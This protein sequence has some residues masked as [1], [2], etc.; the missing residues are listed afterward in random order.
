MRENKQYIQILIRSVLTSQGCQSSLKQYDVYDRH[1]F[2][3]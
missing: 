1:I 2:T 3:A